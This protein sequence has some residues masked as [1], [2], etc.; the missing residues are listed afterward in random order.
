MPY[1]IPDQIPAMAALEPKAQLQ[2]YSYTPKPLG[3]S[4]VNIRVTF[5]GISSTDIHMID[6]DWGVSRYPLA[7]GYEV[8]G[9]IAAKGSEVIGFRGGDVVG[10]SL[11][12]DEYNNFHGGISAFM[13]T[14]YRQLTRIPEEI[15]EKFAGPL[16]GG[17]MAVA[18]PLFNYAGSSWYLKGKRIGI[19]GIGGLGHL[20]IQF[21]SAM[22]AETYAISTSGDKRL[23]CE[24]L[25][26]Q[27]FINSTDPDRMATHT[28][29]LDYLLIC[30]PIDKINDYAGLLRPD[31]LIH[32]VKNPLLSD[33]INRSNLQ[34]RDILEYAAEKS[35]KPLI[36]EFTFQTA[37]DAVSKI[38]DGSVRFRTV[39][40]NDLL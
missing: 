15:C 23:F 4:D 37:N 38:R 35:I 22:G 26:A 20:A 34:L 8:I 10:L 36:E 9:H 39:V 6:N 3:S 5:T 40:K 30:A 13:Q 11:Y 21:A 19:V 24:E 7:P 31:G 12:N 32:M 18:E 2:P 25:G 14:D 27:I 17:G 33:S 29:K 1:K 16:I 28:E